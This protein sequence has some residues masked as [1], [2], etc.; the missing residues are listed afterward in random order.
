MTKKSRY[1]IL[2]ACIVFFM[3]AAPAILMYVRGMAYDTV[4]GAFYKTGILAVKSEPKDVQIKLDGKLSKNGAGT[5]RFIK[6]KE[7]VVSLE[8][9]GFQTWSKRLPVEAARVTWANPAG[10]NIF[11]FFDKPQAQTL[12]EEA[13]LFAVRGETLFFTTPKQLVSAS[14]TKLENKSSYPLSAPAE[15]LFFI[16]GSGL[17]AIKTQNSSAPW[18]IFN[19]EKGAFLSLD[20]ALGSDAELK[21]SDGDL[22]YVLTKNELTAINLAGNKDNPPVENIKDII[23]EGGYFYFLKE[24]NGSLSFY[25]S[26]SLEQAGMLLA[27]KLP[28]AKKTQIILNSQKQAFVLLDQSLYQIGS[29]PSLLAE[30][31]KNLKLNQNKDS[32][33]ITTGS[34]FLAIYSGNNKTELVSRSLYPT[35]DG[36]VLPDLVYGFVVKDNQVIAEELDIRD[37]QNEFLLYPGQG[38]TR[39]FISEDA[40]KL[41]VLDNLKLKVLS[42]R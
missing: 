23:Y 3:L 31:V 5:L 38:P 25:T 2:S 17:L 6:P 34:E 16:P 14:L 20:H 19:P 42:V 28:L 29:Q 36:V 33:A 41:V 7:Y 40:K 39:F 22:L 1:L 13:G 11:L 21:F 9:P 26:P 35:T 32:L 27:Q 30:N 15:R 8:K 18:Q 4:T 24:E 12:S 10:Q 37:R